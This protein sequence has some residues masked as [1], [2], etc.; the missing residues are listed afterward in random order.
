MSFGKK[1]KIQKCICNV[2][3]R[4]GG[5]REAFLGGVSLRIEAMSLIDL[6]TEA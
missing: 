5:V 3:F 2:I 1:L 4:T 6:S